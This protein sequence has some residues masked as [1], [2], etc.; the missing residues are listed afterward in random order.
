MN[1][2]TRELTLPEAI[3]SEAILLTG[4]TYDSM[5]SQSQSSEPTMPRDES[6]HYTKEDLA[7]WLKQEIMD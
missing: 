7:L 4:N 1:G 5:V 6:D 2:V 3:C